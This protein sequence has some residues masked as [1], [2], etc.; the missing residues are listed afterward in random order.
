MLSKGLKLPPVEI[1]LTPET[2]KTI[3]AVAYIIGG[4][5]VIH[6]VSNIYK[7]KK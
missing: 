4:A 6:A 7:L 2:T 5:I 3:M 1:V